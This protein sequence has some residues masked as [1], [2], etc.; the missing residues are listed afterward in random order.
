VIH[1]P[2]ALRQLFGIAA[3]ERCARHRTPPS[4]PTRRSFV[5]SMP[6]TCTYTYTTHRMRLDRL[7]L[8]LHATRCGALRCVRRYNAPGARRRPVLI[9]ATVCGIWS[10]PTSEAIGASERRAGERDNGEA[11]AGKEG[12]DEGGAGERCAAGQRGVRVAHFV[13]SACSACMKYAEQLKTVSTK[14]VPGSSDA[15]GSG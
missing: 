8:S 2:T 7:S 4:G 5:V 1:T 11:G 13:V 9:R 10:C 14:V 15:N 3:C 12:A 6:Y